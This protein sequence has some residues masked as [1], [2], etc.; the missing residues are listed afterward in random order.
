MGKKGRLEQAQSL[1]ARGS[2]VEAEA[3]YR[4]VLQSQPDEVEAMEGLGVL[5]FHSG[6]FDAARAL[7]ERGLPL[8]PDSARLHGNLAEVLRLL[9]RPDLAAGEVQ[10]ALALDP[11][12]AQS[13]NVLGHLALDQ[14]RFGDAVMAYGEAIRLWPRF[15]PGQINFGIALLALHRR[16]EAAEALRAAL[17]IEPDNV[18]ALTKLGQALWEPRD[19]DLVD[20]AETHC[21]RALALAPREPEILENLG[22]VLRLKGRSGEALACYRH[23]LEL[24]PHSVSLR[25]SIGELLL[26]SGRYEDAV[27]VVKEAGDLDPNCARLHV[28]RGSLALARQRFEDAAVHYRAAVALD[29]TLGDA[30]HGLGLALHEQG[31]LDEAERSYRE[32]IR[33]DPALTAPWMDLARLQA[34]RGDRDESC[35]TARGILDLRPN[36]A[37]AYSRLARNLKGDLPDRDIRAIQGLL[38]HRYVSDSLRGAAFRPGSSLRC[39]RSRRRGRRAFRGR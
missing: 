25:L 1:H 26:S 34:E 13:W 7:F 10:T 15:V 23:G 5:M 35:Q 38:E 36:V 39:A 28:Q 29:A 9:G 2:L 18:L 6:R 14:R 24:A 32:A 11:G 17:R 37:D 20:E 4:E 31:L 19:P 12:S 21:R 30:H 27:R 16:N 8:V 3:L 22:Q 33:I